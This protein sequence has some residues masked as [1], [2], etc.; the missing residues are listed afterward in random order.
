[1]D[2][3]LKKFLEELESEEVEVFKIIRVEKKAENDN[4]QFKMALVNRL[5]YLKIDQTNI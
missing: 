5:Q 2:K 1:M 4:L 3:Q